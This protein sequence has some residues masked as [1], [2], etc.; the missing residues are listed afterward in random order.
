MR[1]AIIVFGAISTIEVAPVRHVQAAL[2]R[3]AV[4]ETLSRF[5]NVIAGEFAAD[6]IEKLHA[7]IKEYTAYNNLP[8][9]QSDWERS[10]HRLAT[11]LGDF[12]GRP[13]TRQP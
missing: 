7:M 1:S 13:T 8:A 11:S 5:Q 9:K 10:L 2:Q 4:F 6:F 12:N 3:F